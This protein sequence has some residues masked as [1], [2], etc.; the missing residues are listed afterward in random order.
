MKPTLLHEQHRSR[1]AVFGEEA[2]WS[3]P[4][5]YGD[6]AAEVR[7]VRT[8]AGLADRSHR[9][10]LRLTGEDRGTFLNGLTTNDTRRLSPG[11]G[12]YTLMLTDKAKVLADAR[13]YVLEDSFLL[14]LEP[15]LASPL[16]RHLDRYRVIE[17]V[18]LVDATAELGLL[19][20]AGPQARA[21]VATL[22]PAPLPALE[23]YHGRT[24]TVGGS[25]LVIARSDFTG[26]EGYALFAPAEETP[27]LW[28]ALL[29]AGAAHGLT[30][31]GLEALDVLRVEA[32]VP[33]YGV[34]MDDNTIPLETRLDQAIS[35]TKGCYLG[36]ETIARLLARGHC[37]R[38]LTGFRMQGNALP[39]Q[40]S[41]ILVEEKEVGWITSAALSPTVGGPIALGYLR[42]EYVEPGRTVRVQTEEGAVTAEVTELPFY[43]T[44]TLKFPGST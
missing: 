12:L 2:G 1:G 24:A 37:N 13:L 36:Q 40:G 11:E 18:E 32:G 41:R 21:A 30:P 25:P 42:R 3:V 10:K 23:E 44:R 17:R 39:A 33:R 20:V 8:A 7:A 43:T 5:H 29:A 14:D 34:D 31:V 26:E 6:T 16:L 22:L 35:T 9:G 4:W 15:G 38:F 27:A 28:S 19:L